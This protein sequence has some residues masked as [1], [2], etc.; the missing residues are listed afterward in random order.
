MSRSWRGGGSATLVSLEAMKELEFLENPFITWFSRPLWVSD[1]DLKVLSS[2]LEKWYKNLLFTL[3]SNLTDLRVLTRVENRLSLVNQGPHGG[4]GGIFQSGTARGFECRHL[5]P[6]EVRG[7][8]VGSKY[9]LIFFQI[10]K[11]CVKKF[12]NI[13]QPIEDAIYNMT[14]LVPWKCWVVGY[15][16]WLIKKKS[17]LLVKIVN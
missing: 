8:W 5:D 9:V 3:F 13:K 7:W 1:C 17:H 12:K 2:K 11:L 6:W 16:P 14:Q 15:S 10:W 4:P